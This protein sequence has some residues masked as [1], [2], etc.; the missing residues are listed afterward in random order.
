MPLGRRSIFAILALLLAVF[1]LVP[2]LVADRVEREFRTLAT[3]A[4]KNQAMDLVVS[5]YQRG[6][7]GAE[8]RSELRL[9]VGGET[10]V[11]PLRHDIDHGPTLPRLRA[12][13]VDT[14]L[15]DDGTRDFELDMAIG[16]T[17]AIRMQLNVP[18]F[19]GHVDDNADI[20]VA[21]DGASLRLKLGSDQESYDLEGE[22]SRL[23]LTEGEAAELDVRGVDLKSS[24]HREAGKDV[25][26]WSGESVLTIERGTL[27]GEAHMEASE[28]TEARLGAWQESRDGEVEL[29]HDARFETLKLAN[30]EMGPGD[31]AL[32]LGGLQRSAWD[33]FQKRVNAI[34]DQGLSVEMTET[35]VSRALLETLPEFLA[36]QPHLE[37]TRFELETADGPVSADLQLRMAESPDDAQAA[38][39]DAQLRRLSGDSRLTLP[40]DTLR[41]FIAFNLMN[42]VRASAGNAVSDSRLEA[43][44]AEMARQQIRQLRG[45]GVFEETDD[46]RL[47]SRVELRDGVLLINDAEFS[48][49]F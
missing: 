26:F 34:H 11:L 41:R 36:G 33:A 25:P 45:M 20:R 21:H 44:V 47:E 30:L 8:A 31:Y 42:E 7:F 48:R 19:E 46:E 35:L 15:A 27:D 10:L 1:L 32:R 17:G 29:G 12:A 39:I 14:R 23:V 22:L 16:F 49:L 24:G 4:S 43:V 2:G 38:R 40:E 9:R 6:W 13:R 37:L 18:A 3:T 5:E 28:L